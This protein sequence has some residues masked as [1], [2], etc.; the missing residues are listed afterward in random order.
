MD[1]GLQVR[2]LSLRFVMN[3]KCVD[4]PVYQGE[5]QHGG[6]EHNGVKR[7]KD[8]VGRQMTPI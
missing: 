6:H 1:L 3:R 7:E 8:H 4:G 5:Q 2:A